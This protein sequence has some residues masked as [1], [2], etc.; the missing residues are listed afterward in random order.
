MTK[1]HHDLRDALFD[2]S[3][4]LADI[5][6]QCA[7]IEKKYYLDGSSKTKEDLGNAL[8]KLYRAILHY[9]ALVQM[10]QK[11]SI[12]RKLQNS[13][14]IITEHP[15]TELKNSVEKERD[16]LHKLIG[17]VG[18]LHHEE[19]AESMLHKID[20]LAESM[21]LL[22]EQF[23][24]VNLHVAE[25]AFY[26]S[27]V[28]EHE[29]FCLPGTR[30]ELRS[31]ISEWAKS[32]DGK[33][34]FWLNGMAGTGKSTIARTVA[35]SFKE[36]GLLGAT[37]FFKRGEADRGNAKYLISTIIRQLV[38]SHRGLV[39]YIL[40][41]IKEDLNISSKFLS[42]Q[43]DKLLY[44]PLVKLHLNQL[45]TIV[46]V[47]DALDECDREDDM[48][49]IL[50]LLFKLQEV[51]SVYMRIF[52]TSRPE[53]PIRL[54]FKQDSNHQDLVLHELPKPVIEHD[55]RLFLEHKL[56]EI[57]NGRSLPPAW[58]G[59]KA[60]EALVQIC[61]PL[62]IFA[63]TACRFIEKGTH[64]KK[65]LQKVLEFQAT[66]TANQMDKIYL[67]V[68]NQLLGEDKDDSQ[69][70]L[71]EFR[72]IIGAIILLATPLSIESLGRLLQIP[73]E[74]ISELLDHLNSVLNIPSNMDA[75]VR[76][77]HL[78]FRDY[79]LITESPFRINEQE[80]HEKIALHCLH[81][82]ENKLTHNICGLASYGT[83]R[84]DVDNQIIKQ[85]LS[86]ELEYSCQYWVYHLQQSK[87]RISET[88][89]LP[90]LKRHFL[91]W[92]EALSLLGIISEAVGIID[93]LKSGIWVSLCALYR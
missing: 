43:F 65:R 14:T 87:G 86:A 79:L 1:N 37:F 24:L 26:D 33:C 67:P 12:G 51:K 16:N 30:T 8:I 56:S 7:F 82:M 2:S 68:L 78:S 45:S 88:K 90:F 38:T 74:D 20:E 47:I 59:K 3:E 93:T 91:H 23:S 32:S 44:Q 18:H 52:L 57:Q 48:R 84:S 27:Y 10:T 80:T 71:D 15:L 6:T 31:Q 39:P 62:F 85:Y 54:G 11:A 19:K 40:N 34:I 76:I 61:V 83:Q 92:M 75:P 9:T 55:I 36:Q 66:T 72:H 28:N 4:Y 46:I 29:D 89:I 77:L 41:S 69:E 53:L 70:L 25:G 17:L 81:V 42:E 64:P 60:T 58:P 49:V 22:I 63:A 21:K 13:V 73:G 35:Q 50:R 5:L